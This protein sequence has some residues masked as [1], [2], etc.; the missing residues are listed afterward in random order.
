MG[1]SQPWGRLTCPNRPGIIS[2]TRE[3]PARPNAHLRPV[4]EPIAYQHTAYGYRRTMV[5]LRERC[6]RMVNHKVVQRLYQVWDLPLRQSTCV[7]KPSVIR[8]AITAAGKRVKLVAHLEQ[9]EL[10]QV[11]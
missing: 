2:A 10:F 4:L 3:Y 8:Q 1:W 5:E 9:I 11:A 7:P 6:G